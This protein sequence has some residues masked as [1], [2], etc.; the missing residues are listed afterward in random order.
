M[1]LRATLRRPFHLVVVFY[2]LLSP[3]YFAAPAANDLHTFYG[4]VKAVDPAGKTI[5]LKSGGKSFVFLV[6]N[7][8]KISGRYGAA[9][10]DKIRPGYGAAIVMRVG[11]G[12]HGIARTIRFD[13]TAGVTSALYSLK[14]PRGEIVSGMEFNS[15]VVS[16]KIIGQ[17]KLISCVRAGSSRENRTRSPRPGAGDNRP[18]C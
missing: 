1:N 10:L 14:T 13:P 11:E 4:I 2:F 9:N 18:A 3:S 12:G 7:E 5:N 16:R 17:R 8:T 15:Y 6:T